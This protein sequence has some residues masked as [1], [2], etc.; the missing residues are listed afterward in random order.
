MAY[1][2]TKNPTLG[3]FWRVLQ[4]KMLLRYIYGHLVYFT[5]IWLVCGLLIY[6]KNI[7]YIFSLLGLLYQEKF[8]QPWCKWH[9]LW[10]GVTL[11][12]QATQYRLES[13]KKTFQKCFTEYLTKK[14]MQA[15]VARCL[16]I[17]FGSRQV[18]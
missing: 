5:A 1:F 9:N 3:R 2:H 14:L 4:W 15:K 13:K 6:F 17:V 8:W 7:W 11:P 16:D 10:L 12:T 18:I